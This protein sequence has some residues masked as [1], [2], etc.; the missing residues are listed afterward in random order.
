MLDENT[1]LDTWNNV[2]TSSFQGLW[3]DVIAYIPNL[4]ISIL[5]FIF[6][7]IAAAVLA[8]WVAQI[9]RSLKVDEILKSLGVE[10]VVSRS[11][12]KLD[13]GAFI[14][15][16]VKL[17]IVLAFLIAAFEVL[18]LNQINE[19]LKDLLNY[20]PNVVAAALILLLAAF[21]ADV[22][23]KLVL[24]SAKAASI[25]YAGV[26][27][28]IAKWSIWVFAILI[29]MNQLNIAS[30]FT[31]TLFTGLVAMLALAGGLAFGLGGKEAAT[32][33]LS[34]MRKDISNHN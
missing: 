34:K 17:F 8:H 19:F 11:G 24:A 5:I 3:A 18:G 31:Q 10:E 6:G 16:L 23:H 25:S 13:S 26:A 21:V 27:S 1:L 33:F 9:V 22:V 20:L 30:I 7:W 32:D 4:I 29:A 15:A 28:G 14:G 12:Y 2:L